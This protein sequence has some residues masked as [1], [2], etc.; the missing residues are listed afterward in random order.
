[1]PHAPF[2][3]IGLETTLGLVLTELVQKRVMS[4]SAAIAALTDAPAKAFHL[5]GGHLSP[6]APADLTLIDLKAKYTV[7]KFTS[8]SQ[9]SPFTGRT[10][11]GK[12]H[13][14]LVGG[15]IVMQKGR[16]LKKPLYYGC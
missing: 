13:A 4:L 5:P 2:G 14:T 3:I 15:E 1:M 9:N 16:L 6:G 10:L 12:A 11:Q 7:N 8:K